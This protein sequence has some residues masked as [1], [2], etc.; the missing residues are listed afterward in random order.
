M[1][2]KKKQLFENV[3]IEIESNKYIYTC[4]QYE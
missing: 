4:T 1:L 3:T 2:H